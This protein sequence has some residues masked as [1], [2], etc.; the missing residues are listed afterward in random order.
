MSE[1]KTKGIIVFFLN[2]NS[3]IEGVSFKD[4]IDMFKELNSEFIKKIEEETNYRVS[5]VPTTKEASRIEKVD[6]DHPFPRFVPN[7]VD[8][9][10]NEQNKMMVRQIME[11]KYKINEDKE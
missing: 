2:Y 5:I 10:E 7:N 8:I 1:N 11:R 6:F 4:Q 9:R 3:N